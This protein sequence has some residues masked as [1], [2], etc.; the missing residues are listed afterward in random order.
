[1]PGKHDN[2][3]SLCKHEVKA[4]KRVL[5]AITTMLQYYV[6]CFTA[7]FYGGN[8][9]QRTKMDSNMHYIPLCYLTI[10]HAIFELN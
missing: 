1:M 3:A 10:S 5:I 8:D 4:Q 2:N 9:T 7:T 6:V